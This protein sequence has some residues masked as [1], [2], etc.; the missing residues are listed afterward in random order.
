MMRA[1][2]PVLIV[3]GPV[4]VGKTSV[5]HEMFD[6]LSN[7]DISHA[8]IDLDGLSICWPVGENDPFNERMAMRN[9]A[10]IWSNFA[11]AGVDRAIIA[12]VVESRAD[13]AEYEQAIRGAEIQ[14]CQLTAEVA[15]L[16]ERVGRREVGSSY[17]PLVCRAAEL[18]E[19]LERSGAADFAVQT[20]GR[21]LADI[22]IEAL[23]KAGW[24]D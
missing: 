8:V 1:R 24:L 5:V 7:R 14:V 6:Q 21:P 20:D 9:L 17:E 23:V 12:R 15:V 2:I 19:S 18:A 16:R 4:G 13:L 10:A 3:S 22:A 11:A